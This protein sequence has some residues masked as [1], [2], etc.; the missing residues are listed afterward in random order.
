MFVAKFTV[1]LNKIN[2]TDS[3]F[4]PYQKHII[5]LERISTGKEY[6]DINE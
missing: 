6:Y 4:P 3:L 1:L 5:K 2:P